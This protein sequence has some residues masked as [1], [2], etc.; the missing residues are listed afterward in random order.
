[1]GEKFT[2][3]TNDNCYEYDSDY[4]NISM[5]EEEEERFKPNA[6]DICI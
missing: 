4:F 2:V 5:L 3:D 6:E 1:M